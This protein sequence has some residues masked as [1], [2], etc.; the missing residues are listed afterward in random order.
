MLFLDLVLN[1]AFCLFDK[2]IYLKT[3]KNEKHDMRK[4]FIEIHIEH[5][6]CLSFEKNVCIIIKCKIY[7][8]VLSF[9]KIFKCMKKCVQFSKIFKHLKIIIMLIEKSRFSRFIFNFKSS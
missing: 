6:N 2:D 7:V 4:M 3:Y 1:G 8:W 5:I 9:I